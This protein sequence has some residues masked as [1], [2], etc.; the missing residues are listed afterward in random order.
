MQPQQGFTVVEDGG[1]DGV[2]THALTFALLKDTPI[3]AAVRYTVFA[4]PAGSHSDNKSDY[5]MLNDGTGRVLG[6]AEL[7]PAQVS[8][9]PD[10]D[11]IISVGDVVALEGSGNP[12]GILIGLS[13]AVQ[14]PVSVN[15]ATTDGTATDGKDYQGAKGTLTFAPGETERDVT[16][17]VIGD[18]L[19]ES[20]ETFDLDLTAATGATIADARG[21]VTI[22]EDDD[23]LP[24]VQLHAVPAATPDQPV[25]EARI[26]FSEPV[27]GF[28]LS[29]L[30][31]TRNDQVVPLSGVSLVGDGNVWSLRG[32]APLNA[33]P[34]HYVLTLPGGAASGITDLA[35]NPLAD[36]ASDSWDVLRRGVPPVVTQVYVA[37]S[38]WTSAYRSYLQSK[39]LG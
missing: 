7:S 32:L 28:D 29:E 6:P 20:D 9:R 30:V 33:D 18:T 4:A 15:F 38:G 37:G 26:S 31:L 25:D 12:A 23:R 27:K 3:D 10:L 8:S 19:D 17:A 1:V 14:G 2:D 35:G 24:A 11:T 5:L 36:G 16:V 22:L 13:R 34:G 39:G 21:V